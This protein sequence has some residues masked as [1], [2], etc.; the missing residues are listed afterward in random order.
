LRRVQL[1]SG[2]GGSSRQYLLPTAASHIHAPGAPAAGYL[3]AEMTDGAPAMTS[4]RN[5]TTVSDVSASDFV[6]LEIKM[7]H[8]ISLNFSKINLLETRHGH[9]FCI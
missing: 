8:K 4:H 6:L 9:F 7:R 3:A 5:N 1:P 2:D